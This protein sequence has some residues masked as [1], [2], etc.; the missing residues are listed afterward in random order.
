MRKVEVDMPTMLVT[1][2]G[3]VLSGGQFFKTCPLLRQ[4]DMRCRVVGY[5]TTT[6]E[7]IIIDIPKIRM[8]VC[9]RAFLTKKHEHWRK[10]LV[11]RP[12][13]DVCS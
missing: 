12:K 7:G 4:H 10:L 13:P 9:V 5:L 3:E 6:F 8:M 1:H 11:D 2:K